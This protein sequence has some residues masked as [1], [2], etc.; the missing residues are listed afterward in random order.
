MN[1]RSACICFLAVVKTALLSSFVRA[2]AA[3]AKTVSRVAGPH[4]SV[5]GDWNPGVEAVQN[6]LLGVHGIDPSGLGL[7]EML[8]LHDNA[9]NRMGNHGHSHQKKPQG[10]SKGYSKF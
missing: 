6:H 9:H 1:R 2:A 4:W 8:A 5:N 10:F 3:T 7:D